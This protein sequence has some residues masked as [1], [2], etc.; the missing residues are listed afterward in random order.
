MLLNVLKLGRIDYLDAYNLQLDYVQKR[1]SGDVPDTL[2]LLEHPPVLTMGRHADQSNIRADQQTLKTNHVD[3]HHIERGGDVTYHGP[4][5]LV[6]YMI[7]DISTF[8]EDLKYLV[9]AIEETFIQFL[10]KKFHLD[11][12]RDPI[13]RGVWLN[14]DKICAIGLSVRKG[15][16]MHGFAFN[17]DPDLNHYRWIVPCGIE[18][19]GA[20]S[21]AAHLKRKILVDSLI[22]G[23]VEHYATAFGYH[24]VMWS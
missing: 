11:S 1:R 10:K 6:G 12:R 13:N 19:R 21:L 22:E 16:S 2:L 3:V 8:N 23:V 17:V 18:G 24:S 4:G 14:G 20:T 15:I 9:W 7:L 5:Q